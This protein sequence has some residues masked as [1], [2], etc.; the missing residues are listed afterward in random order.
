[1]HH[2]VKKNN[3]IISQFNNDKVNPEFYIN[4][5]QCQQTRACRANQLAACFGHKILLEH[6]RAHLFI[7]C[8]WMLSYCNGRTD[9]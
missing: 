2:Q 8:L 5:S 7:F 3:V 1:M 4:L 6:S 9:I